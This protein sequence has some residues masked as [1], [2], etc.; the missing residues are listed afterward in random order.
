MAWLYYNKF[1]FDK[2]KEKAKV[3]V[4]KT[5]KDKL[6]SS[7]GSGTGRQVV[8][9]EETSDFSLFKKAIV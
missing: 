8:K 3:E 1:N 5:L 2:L 6:N 9:K 4:T 7:K